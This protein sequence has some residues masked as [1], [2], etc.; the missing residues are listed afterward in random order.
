MRQVKIV[1]GGIHPPTENLKVLLSALA[2]GSI[3]SVAFFL[4]IH[5]LSPSI[6]IEIWEHSFP[7]TLV[8]GLLASST[9]LL[10][11]SI[12]G[13]GLR[14][15]GS[16]VAGLVLCAAVFGALTP[17]GLVA[18]AAVA[19]LLIVSVWLLRIAL[20][21]N[22]G[23]GRPSYLEAVTIASAVTVAE[24]CLWIL[25]TAPTY[26]EGF[27][28]LAW[29]L[30]GLFNILLFSLS[31]L[32]LRLLGARPVGGNSPIAMGVTW[33]LITGAASMAFFW[34]LY[35]E[36]ARY[37]PLEDASHWSGAFRP[38]NGEP[39]PGSSTVVRNWSRTDIIELLESRRKKTASHLATLAL[40]TQQKTWAEAFKSHLLRQASLSALTGPEDS[41]KVGQHHATVLG[42]YFQLLDQR[43]PGLFDADDR[44]LVGNWLSQVLAAVFELGWVD[45]LYAVPFRIQPTGPYLN[46]EVGAGAVAAALPLATGLDP[47]L[48]SQAQDHLDKM[49][50]G[51]RGN[52]RNQDDSLNYQDLWMQS[53]FSLFRHA[54]GSDPKAAPGFELAV[55]W[56]KEQIPLSGFPLNYGFPAPHRPLN[57]LAFGAFLGRDGESKWLLDRQLDAMREKGELLPSDLFGFWLW[58]DSVAPIEPRPASVLMYGPSGYAFK[59]GRLEP[60]KVVFRSR[61]PLTSSS[62][63]FAL[64]GLRNSGWHRYPA[65]NTLVTLMLGGAPL[66]SEDLIDRWNDWL[67]DGRAQH[68]DK[69]IDRSRLNGLAIERTGFDRWIGGITGVYSRWR[70]DVP[71]F[72]APHIWDQAGRIQVAQ[73]DLENWDGVPQRRWYLYWPSV[74]FVIVDDV[75]DARRREKALGWHFTGPAY[76]AFGGSERRA[77]ESPTLEVPIV[78]TGDTRILA[79]EAVNPDRPAYPDSAPHTR[80]RVV[81]SSKRFAAAMIVPLSSF[82]S[83]R[84]ES[85]ENGQLLLSVRRDQGREWVLFRGDVP[86][87]HGG[88]RSDARV[89]FV[90]D[91]PGRLRVALIQATFLETDVPAASSS[92]QGEPILPEASAD[93]AR[94]VLDP[95]GEPVSG[96]LRLPKNEESDASQTPSG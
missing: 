2:A 26:A 53:A 35:A 61:S 47:E 87:E 70:Q 90:S 51:W 72:A 6:R 71:A 40:L 52:F 45:Y 18:G 55:R 7:Q 38:L 10:F 62:E 95:T 60:D 79:R 49:S 32:A 94:F 84:L 37:E 91:Q 75:R 48:R 58:D 4:S 16:A 54:D 88:F 15:Q 1:E 5:A 78:A 76:P 65:T 20:R 41:I 82:T 89:M 67:P 92:W 66:L 28:L 42:L 85:G 8:Y 56:A 3:A 22:R 24:G 96:T 74:G 43:F 27:V 29:F 73:V 9:A 14:A 12:V 86:G 17:V 46:Q 68:R 36:G 50:V 64:I 23:S 59:P 83:P 31:W 34:M 19:V 81:N 30:L 80:V 21:R 39:E 13:Q 44:R 11:W 25:T 57:L 77:T 93:G 33:I 63:L 69:R